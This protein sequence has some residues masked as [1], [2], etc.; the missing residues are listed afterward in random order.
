M[1]CSNSHRSSRVGPRV[2]IWL[3]ALTTISMSMCTTPARAVINDTDWSLKIS[4]REK[5]FRPATDMAAMKALMWEL[6]SSRMFARNLPFICLTNESAT[7]SITQFKMTIG[8]TQFQFNNSLMG[9]YAKLGKDTPGYSLSSSVTDGGDT[10]IVNFLNGGIAPGQS[11][12]FQFD[13]DSDPQFANQFFTNPDYRTVLFDLN[14]DNYYQTA[15]IINDPDSSDNSKV[16]ITFS[17]ANMPSV[18]VG[19]TPFDDPSVV[20]GSAGFVNAN[21]A[22]YGDSDPIRAFAL[23]G[24]VAIPEPTS[25]A[26][27]LCGLVALLPQLTRYRRKPS[28]FAQR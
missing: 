4:E 13:I 6:P 18:T 12:N 14:G 25:V 27:G 24:G 16:S 26:L 20:D 9:M 22:R 2:A 3:L 15:G 1:F 21:R 17:M 19:P 8:D 5:A 7:A 10:L 28:V 23:A 11:A